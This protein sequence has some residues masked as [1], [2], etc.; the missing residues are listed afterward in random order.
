MENII[1]KASEGGYDFSR[2]LEYGE[3]RLLDPLFWEAL[4]KACGWKSYVWT[5]YGEYRFGSHNNEDFTDD[6]NFTPPTR[7]TDTPYARRHIVWQFYAMR[8]HELNLTSDF[9]TA[10]K[11]LEKLITK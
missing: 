6:E 2:K 8:F 10:V 7:Y 11:W 5:S 3:S 4:G 9:P 1:S